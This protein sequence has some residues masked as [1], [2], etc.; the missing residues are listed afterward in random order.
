MDE[1]SNELPG[2]GVSIA[3]DENSAQFRPHEKQYK[4]RELLARDI[5]ISITTYDYDAGLARALS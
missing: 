5:I 1:A 2:C 4:C 3:C